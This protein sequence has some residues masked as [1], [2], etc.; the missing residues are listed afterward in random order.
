MH[1]DCVFYLI[2][3]YLFQGFWN[4]ASARPI[5]NTQETLLLSIPIW[6]QVT[7]FLIILSC[8]YSL[9]NYK[10]DKLAYLTPCSSYVLLVT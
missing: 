8:L 6:I 3:K 9:I 5:G 2:F 1:F 7:Q 10:C 4:S